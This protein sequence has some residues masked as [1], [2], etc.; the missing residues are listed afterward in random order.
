MRCSRLLLLLAVFAV[1]LTPAIASDADTSNKVFTISVAAPT[2]P[3]D[4]QVRYFLSGQ[5]GG[6]FAATTATGKEDKIVIRT[7]RESQAAT[8]FRAIAYAPGCEFVTITVDDLASSNREAEFQCQKLPTT[9][10]QGRI[11]TAGFEGKDLQVEVLYVC[12]WAAQ[13]FNIGSGAVSPLVLTKVPVATDGTFAIDMPDFAA[14]PLW[15]SFG[16]NAAL[17]FTL[18][19]ASG[20]V[21]GTLAP[22]SDLASGTSL[23]V[24]GAYPS[25]MEFTLQTESAKK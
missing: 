6:F 23:K 2:L 22:P 7:E 14:D 15:S 19:D 9:L 24:A 17:V 21:L 1:Y 16:Q 12:N 8:G 25:E 10:L 4:I 11:S 5:F 20:N 13:F 18:R 3:K